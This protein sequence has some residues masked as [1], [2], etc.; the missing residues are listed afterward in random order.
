MCRLW[1]DVYRWVKDNVLEQ[2]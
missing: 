1:P 2:L